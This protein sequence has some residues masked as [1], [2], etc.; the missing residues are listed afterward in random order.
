M[1]I[2]ELIQALVER[3]DQ[4][5]QM[6]KID[7]PELPDFQVLNALE[8]R[9]PLD[10]MKAMIALAAILMEAG[11][12]T[13]REDLTP[14]EFTAVWLARFLTVVL[15]D[16]PTH[17]GFTL[18]ELMGNCMKYPTITEGKDN[19]IV[20]TIS[21]QGPPGSELESIG[22]II[23][24]VAKALGVDEDKVRTMRRTPEME[25]QS[26]KGFLN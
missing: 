6:E 20:R 2:D 21:L 11:R 15:A 18:G 8:K 12:V 10:A 23:E 3:G 25:A 26:K 24:R 22:A 14:H 4:I 13:G 1:S 5:Y 7:S 16:G 9:T 19:D 17:V